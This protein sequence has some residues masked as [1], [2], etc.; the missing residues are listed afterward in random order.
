MRY[1][2]QLNDFELPATFIVDR[3]GLQPAWRLDPPIAPEGFDKVEALSKAL[4]Q[5][6]GAWPDS[7]RRPH[8]ASA[9]HD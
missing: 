4:M 5:S 1:L 8:L 2:L 6:S 9:I 7:E 3:N